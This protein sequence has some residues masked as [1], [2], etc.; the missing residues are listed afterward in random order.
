MATR[1]HSRLFSNDIVAEIPFAVACHG[2]LRVSLRAY[3]LLNCLT[4]T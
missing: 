4:L 3:D 1:R 2:F